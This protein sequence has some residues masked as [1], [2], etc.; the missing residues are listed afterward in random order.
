MDKDGNLTVLPVERKRR[1]DLP[2]GKE[3]AVL[4]TNMSNLVDLTESNKGCLNRGLDSRMISEFKED[5]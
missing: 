3:D 4:Y 5:V 2:V 1:G